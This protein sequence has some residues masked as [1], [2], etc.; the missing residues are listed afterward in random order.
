MPSGARIPVSIQPLNYADVPAAAR[1][2][3]SAFSVDP[4]TIVKNLGRKPYD[5]YEISS[6]NFLDTLHKN[7]YIYVKAVDD[8]TG[9]IVGH[10]GWAFRGV[11]QTLIPRSGPGDAK[12]AG[13][14]RKQDQA[15]VNDDG[16][17]DVDK[18]DCGE[19]KEETS[20]DRL[21]ALEDADMQ[22]WLSNI[23][24]TGTPCMFVVG[25]IV[26]PAFQSRGV[27]GALMRH[28]NDIADKLGL[29]IWVHSSHQAYEAYKK[30]GFRAVKELDIDLDEYAPRKPQEGEAIMG[31]KGSG[32]WGRYVIRYMERKPKKQGNSSR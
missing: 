30:F 22:F 23:V 27:G 31:E 19:G 29:S 20:I 8:E 17:K 16:P 15:Q 2:T 3:S 9:E 7:N 13:L 1:I 32:K 18:K 4:H 24:P 6:T 25:L 21:H 11:D 12:P 5:M 26:S 28:G 10:A 14:E